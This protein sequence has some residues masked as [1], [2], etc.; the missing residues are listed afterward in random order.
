MDTNYISDQTSNFD[1]E[2]I[3]SDQH[4]KIKSDEF[5]CYFNIEC[6]L[7]PLLYIN[8]ECSYFF[9]KRNN[10]TQSYPLAS[11]LRIL[12]N[13]IKKLTPHADCEHFSAANIF[14]FCIL[15][16]QLGVGIWKRS[17]CKDIIWKSCI[18]ALGKCFKN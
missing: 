3:S 4:K 8:S 9:V 17:I 12:K 14:N 11:L 1:T 7:A 16:I 10:Y 5:I 18:E 6:L 2:L 13:W 15:T